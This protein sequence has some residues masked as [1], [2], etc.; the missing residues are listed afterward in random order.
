MNEQSSLK[1]GVI[2]P[3]PYD[4]SADKPSLIGRAR[5]LAKRYRHFLM[6]VIAPT[7]AVAAFYYLV[8][9]DQY[10]S[11]AHFL[12]HSTSQQRDVPGGL[13]SMLSRGGMGAAN[14][15]SL[16]VSDYLSS[17]DAVRAL[18]AKLD[19]VGRFRAP[20]AD[21]VSKLYP[22]APDP[23]TLFKY[24]QRRVDV[25]YDTDTG[26]TALK[27]RS[28][29][30]DDSYEIIKALLQLG[31]QRVNQMNRRSYLDAIALSR[32]Q[33]AEAE[34]SVTV[35]QAAL[36]NFRQTERDIDPPSSSE[37]QT[38]LVSS[39]ETELSATRAQLASMGSMISASSPQYQALAARVRALEAQVASQN[40][41]LT[42]GP[43][44]I[45]ASLGN[46]ESL[47][48][49]QEFA[50]KRYETAAGALEKARQDALKQQLYITRVV[51]PNLPVRSLYPQRGTL[52]LTVF[53]ALLVMYGLGWLIV[54][55]VREHAA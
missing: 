10:Q 16:S 38:R 17:H 37:A 19:L 42:G 35:A 15:E 30:P 46:Y 5:Q 50:A 39:V 14:S 32:E 4:P 43:R 8:A 51:E 34:Q 20:E 6:F 36:T 45:A 2:T 7:L 31:E 18:N 40:Q 22:A 3:V 12:V 44:A 9:A 53:V 29:R 13:S 33:L 26:I 55:G 54:A 28:F 11:E 47:R 41:R 23:E 48:L 27:V 21:F 24:Y 1:L 49:K 52:L 25:H